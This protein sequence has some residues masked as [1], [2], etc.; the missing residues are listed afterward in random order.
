MISGSLLL[1]WTVVSIYSS[2]HLERETDVINWLRPAPT[3]F[4][5]TYNDGKQYEPNFVVKTDDLIYLVEVK[6]EDKENDTD[7]LAKKNTIC[8]QLD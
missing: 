3:E 5:L 1:S 6:G 7:V 8:R 4:N 2:S